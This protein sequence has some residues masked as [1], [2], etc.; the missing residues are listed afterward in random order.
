MGHDLVENGRAVAM[1]VLPAKPETLEGYAAGELQEYVKEITGRILPIINEPEGPEG[2]GDYNEPQ[3][4]AGYG[5]W[6]GQTKAAEAAGFTRTEAELGR[7]GYAA[8]ADEKGLVLVGRCPLGT[9]FGVY[10]LIEREF[11]VRW[12][13]PNEQQR[14]LTPERKQ[15]WVQPE[16]IGEVIPKADSLW[17]GTFRREFKP[18]FEY[19]WVREG[20]W[21]LCNR[22]NVWVRVNGQI[23]GV[24][25][26]WYGHAFGALVPPE[27]YFHEH[28][29]WFA[30]V[31]GKRRGITDPEGLGHD[32]QLCTSNPEVIEKL[33]QRLIETIEADPTIEVISLSA[34]DGGGF[35]ECENCKALD[36]PPRADL[37]MPG[38]IPPW[39]YSNRFAIFNNEVARRVAKR[40]PN[41][42]IKVFAYGYYAMPPDI[43]NFRVEPNLQVQICRSDDRPI[44]QQWAAPTDQLGVYQYYAL[45]AW[46]KAQVLRAVVHEMRDDIPWLRDRGVKAFF[47]QY[48]QQPWY[49]CPLN[50]Y[51]AAK[52]VW[53][54]DLD[55]DWLIHDYCDKFFQQAAAPMRD[56][57][58]E[59]EQVTIRYEKNGAAAYDQS[60]RDKLR[61]LLDKAQRLANSELVK[62]RVAALR[63]GFDACEYSV[64]YNAQKKVK[65]S[66]GTAPKQAST[67]INPQSPCGLDFYSQG[68]VAVDG[69]AY[70][71]ANDSCHRP[72]LIRTADNPCVAAIDVKTLQV[73]R[74]YK[75]SFTYDSSPLVFPTKD[76]TWL[77]IAHEHQKARTVAMNRDTGAVAWTSAANQP[78]PVFFGYSYFL[79]PDGSRLIFMSSPNGLHA[80]AGETGE[81][82]WWLK[83]RSSGGITPCVDQARGWIFYQCDGRILKVRAGD[84]RFS[85]PCGV[86]KPASCV[87][88]NTV[89][90][91]DSHGYYVATYWYGAKEWD[92]AIRVYDKD[93]DLLWEKAGLPTG[94]KATLTY[95]DGKLVTGSGNQWG[96]LPRRHVE[97]Y[98][99]LRNRHGRGCL[100]MQLVEVC[101][102]GDPERAVLQR[103]LL[104]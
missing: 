102:Y 43:K 55:V 57:L 9:L 54:A 89:L 85:N 65:L 69:I 86:A 59:I 8:K 24:N 20:D 98:R 14:T 4:L 45:A 72:G 21:A 76:G 60:T 64:L 7:D 38:K 6:L 47:T 18:S 92:G 3:K 31:K 96:A 17:V 95:A 99:R 2:F 28:P 91:D 84:G 22:M 27:K 52:L 100:E 90:I 30:L 93:L 101:L 51:I 80:L 34:N 104:R 29:E 49:Q 40:F 32:S 37:H 12:F 46:G 39:L 41:V 62:K 61:S 33:S 73:L 35:C 16:P 48:M 97:I 78:G 75:F 58:L 94:K 42:K 63:G 82:V 77:V 1:I 44:V 13:V 56:Y 66:A 26:K 103:L 15:I 25:C 19:R 5:I 50:H 79:R 70:F 87:S 68:G 83:Q 71:T 88:W 74:R 23:V 53:N 36:G 81:D 67:Q 11:G 10:D